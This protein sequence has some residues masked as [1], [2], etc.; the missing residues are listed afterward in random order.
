MISLRIGEVEV[1]VDSALEAAEVVKEL[2]TKGVIRENTVH[3]KLITATC[4][5]CGVR[6][7][8]NHKQR[9]EGCRRERKKQQNKDY[10][11]KRRTQGLPDRHCEACGNLLEDNRRRR[12]PRC[13]RPKLEVI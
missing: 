7:D 6:L 1:K 3:A 13:S 10:N 2:R 12:C 5:D 11:E 8:S 4:I 9:C